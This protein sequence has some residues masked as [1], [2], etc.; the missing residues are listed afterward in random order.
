MASTAV[1]IV[2]DFNEQAWA[3]CSW[4]ISSMCCFK[5]DLDPLPVTGLCHW[6]AWDL[7]LRSLESCSH[8]SLITVET[9]ISWSLAGF[10]NQN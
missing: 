5:L 1:L 10:E 2:A 8:T 9:D 3:P 6:T 4:I 7:V